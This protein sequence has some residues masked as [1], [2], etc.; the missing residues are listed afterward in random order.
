MAEDNLTL[1]LDGSVS[2]DDFAVAVKGLQGLVNAIS[3]D[4]AK[5][6]R[7]EWVLD[8]LEHGSAITTVRGFSQSPESVEAVVGAYHYV[9][10]ALQ[11]D[12]KVPYSRQVRHHAQRIYNILQHRHRN[13]TAIRF[14][15]PSSTV[16]VRPKATLLPQDEGLVS[17]F[18]AIEGRIQTLTSR[19][20]LRFT[21][22]DSIY[23][24]PVSCYLK[25]GRE[26]AMRDAWGRRAVIEGW[27]SRDAKTNRPFTVRQVENIE[28]LPEVPIG[29]FRTARGLVSFTNK[30]FNSED[31]IR[32]VRDAE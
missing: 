32:Q 17:S 26:D 25:V 13:V 20:G 12:K 19:G 30:D 24:K 27:V 29:A 4:V 5:K 22:Y 18:G 31:F 23:D 9:G 28:L 11:S 14:E 6:D 1:A 16:I 2:L 8:A 10:E 15:T 3:R 21:L 7:I